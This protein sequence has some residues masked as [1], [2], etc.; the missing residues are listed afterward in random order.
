MSDSL[1]IDIKTSKLGAGYGYIAIFL[2]LFCFMAGLY[3]GY[4]IAKK[5]VTVEC[6]DYIDNPLNKDEI[7]NRWYNDA[8]R[9]DTSPGLF[10]GG[11]GWNDSDAETELS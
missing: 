6:N 8:N 7:M 5:L 9:T 1:A 11:I 4:V 2:I 10:P 3:S